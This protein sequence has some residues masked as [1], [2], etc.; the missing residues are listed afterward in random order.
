MS[1]PV[2]SRRSLSHR[3]NAGI[4]RMLVL[5][6]I[7]HLVLFGLVGGFLVPRFEQ[8]KKPVYFVDLMQ[9]PVAKPRSGRPDAPASQKKPTTKKKPV[10]KQEPK[11][12]PAVK[13]PVQPPATK[14]TPEVVN[15]PTPKTPVVRETKPTPVPTPTPSQSYEDETL[16]AIERLKQK[17]RIAQ[18]KQ[19]LNDLATRPTPATT[20]VTA[21][22]GVVGGRGDE[23]GVDFESWI[24]E[25]L[26]AAWAL[27]S[28][29][30][31]RGLVAKMNLQFS[32][33]GRLTHYE[34]VSPSGDSFFDATVKRAVRQLSQLPNKPGRPLEL[35]VTF[36]PKEM[37]Q[38]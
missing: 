22:V 17:Q 27:P 31:Q 36:D 4:G 13:P 30:L 32:A 38:R 18:L 7:L 6:L 28:H 20:T 25:Y 1:E 35:I 37:L 12:K 14:K 15:K 23:A 16:D 26:S 5:S 24:K 9:K 3:N 2:S 10:V 34:M 8:P 11:S 21:P 19:E 29:Y 33:D